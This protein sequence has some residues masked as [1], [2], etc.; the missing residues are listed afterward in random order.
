MIKDPGLEGDTIS[1][2]VQVLEGSLPARAESC[3]LFID[4]FGTAAFAGLARR[5]EPSGAAAPAVARR[6][7]A[8]AALGWS[9]SVLG[10]SL[11]GG[12]VP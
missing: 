4:P 8:P 2:T 10:E 9:L 12:G 7:T 11:R 1:Y 3:S 5:H 6:R